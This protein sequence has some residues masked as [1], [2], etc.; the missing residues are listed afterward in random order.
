MKL[1]ALLSDL[2]ESEG[3]K[4]FKSENPDTFFAAFF[5]ILDLEKST[6]QLQLDFFLPE[7]NKVAAFELPK[8]EPRVHE[9]EIKDMK[10]QPT[11]I[12]IDIDNIKQK[13]QE[14]IEKNEAKLKPTKIIA[15]LRDNEWNLTCMDNTLGIIRI[16]L[17]A[18]TGEQKSFDKGSMMDFMKI[19]KN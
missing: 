3:Y 13:A 12:K 6:E 14:I 2:K 5:A 18:N 8:E 10:P 16:K 1:S 7:K 19:K 15:V 17:D 9:D 4:K 11:E